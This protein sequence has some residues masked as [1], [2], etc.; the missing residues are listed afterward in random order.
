MTSGEPAD[1]TEPALEALVERAKLGDR[2]AFEEVASRIQNKIYGLSVKMLWHPEDARDATQEILI[3]VITNLGSYRGESAFLT[4]AYRVAANYLLTCR[5]SRLEEQR[6]TFEQ[7]GNELDQGLSHLPVK[8]PGA[9]E[10]LLLEEVK[11]GCTL[12]MLTCLDRPHRMAYI[13]GEILE[14]GHIEAAEI[15]GI[16]PGAFRKRLS[17]ARSEITAFTQ[18]KCGLINPKNLCRCRRRVGYALNSARI[19]AKRLLFASD[20]ERARGFPVVLREIRRLEELRRAAALYRSHPELAAPDELM[21][22]LR[23]LL[24]DRP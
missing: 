13:L 4:W 1:G 16:Q 9:E 6:Y 24:A 10:A 17:R 21:S 7:F 11:I 2:A 12:G 5:K 14:L 3:R 18:A 15:L 8:T 19:D 22:V 20:I 23:G